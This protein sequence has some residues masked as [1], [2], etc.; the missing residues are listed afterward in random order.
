MLVIARR[1]TVVIHNGPQ[2]W[3]VVLPALTGLLGAGLVAWW[4]GRR[5]VD[6]WRRDTRLKAFAEFLTAHHEIERAL[7]EYFAASKSIPPGDPKRLEYGSKISERIND[8]RSGASIIELVGQYLRSQP[9]SSASKRR[10]VAWWE[11]HPPGTVG[12]VM[13][14]R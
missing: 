2:W 13:T 11:R 5:G 9:Q 12:P 14:P 8:V 10:R 4:Q 1:T 3:L 6:R 7:V